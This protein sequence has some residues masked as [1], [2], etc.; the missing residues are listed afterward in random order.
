MTEEFVAVLKK[1]II[2]HSVVV[3]GNAKRCHSLLMDYGS[4]HEREIKLFVKA[5]EKDFPEK[6]CKSSDR[7][8]DKKLLAESWHKDDFIDLE[9]AKKMLNC[10]CHVLFNDP[11]LD[12]ASAQPKIEVPPKIEDAPK[13][14][15][16]VVKKKVEPVVKVEPK[17]IFT[18]ERDGKVY[19]IV[20]ICNQIWMAENLNYNAP[21]SKFY[22]NDP[23]NGE[24]YGRLYDWETAN[25]VCPSGWHLP[26]KDEWNALSGFAG[27]NDIEGKHLKAKEGWNVGGSGQDTYGFTALPGGYGFSDGSFLNVGHFGCWWVASEDNYGAYSRRL[28][29]SFDSAG[30]SIYDKK[31][32]FSVRCLKN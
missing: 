1:L 30:W 2:D 6:I 15:A 23:K 7:A 24:I 12:E 18:D 8:A 17:N 21:G 9:C 19:R 16:P 25:K 10:L 26:S 20:K 27:G 28:Y 11:L 3:L 31:Y 32:L 22:E 4:E 14:V 5:L 29:Y 13:V